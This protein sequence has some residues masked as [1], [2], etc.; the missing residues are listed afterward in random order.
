MVSSSSRWGAEPLDQFRPRVAGS[1]VGRSHGEPEDGG[2]VKETGFDPLHLHFLYSKITAR[3]LA[4]GGVGAVGK[5]RTQYH[6]PTAQ[7][8][9]GVSSSADAHAH[10]PEDY[11]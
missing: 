7:L 2:E 6:R 9:Q 4:A 11:R 1:P 10:S 3:L 5:L 8:V